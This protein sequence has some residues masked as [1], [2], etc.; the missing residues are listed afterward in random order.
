[1]I[2]GRQSR[3]IRLTLALLAC[4]GVARA[5]STPPSQPYTAT[6]AATGDPTRVKVLVYIKLKSGS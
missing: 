6:I 3:G 4:I 1:M 5:Q 2:P